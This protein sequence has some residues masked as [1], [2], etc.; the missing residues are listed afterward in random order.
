MAIPSGSTNQLESFTPLNAI[1]V[2]ICGLTFSRFVVPEDGFLEPTDTT[3]Q[4]SK[5]VPS[6]LIQTTIRPS[7]LLLTMVAS[8]EVHEEISDVTW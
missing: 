3:V 5:P 2:T 7:L 6:I 4:S 8:D 1:L